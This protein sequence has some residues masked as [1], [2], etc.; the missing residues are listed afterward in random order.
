VLF[1]SASLIIVGAIT[2]TENSASSIELYTPLSAVSSTTTL[3][4]RSIADID[5]KIK[6]MEINMGKTPFLNGTTFFLAGI[7]LF[8]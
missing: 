5:M 3:L 8:L 7:D 4:D 6:E 1:R 2:T